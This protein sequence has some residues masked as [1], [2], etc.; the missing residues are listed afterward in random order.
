MTGNQVPQK[1][2]APLCH[3]ERSRGIVLTCSAINLDINNDDPF[4]P[5][6]QARDLHLPYRQPSSTRKLSSP[7]AIPSEAEESYFHVRQPTSTSVTAIRFI[8][9]RRRGICTCHT[10]NQVPKSG[11]WNGKLKALERLRPIVFF[12]CTRNREHGASDL[13]DLRRGYSDKSSDTQQAKSFGKASPS[14][15][16][17]MYAETRTW[18]TRLG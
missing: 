16:L 2:L 7:F 14:R 8:P 6:P 5:E 9:S 1:S 3:S 13:V 4:H 11:L 17:P 12:P 18:G 15:F 10:G